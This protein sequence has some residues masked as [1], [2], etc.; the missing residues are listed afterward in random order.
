MWNK[1][2]NFIIIA[3]LLF[4]GWAIFID[5]TLYKGL[6]KSAN[7]NYTQAAS[8]FSQPALPLPYTGVNKVMF[9][10]GF[11]P[12]SIKTSSANGYNYFVKIV[13]AGTNQELGSYFIRSGETLDTKVPLGTYEM[14]CATG[15]QWYGTLH[16]FGPETRYSKADPPLEFYFDGHIY[17]G[18]AI[19]LIPQINGNLKTSVIIPS[20]W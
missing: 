1:I 2:Q 10:D 5:D 8:T 13:Y 6:P 9:S 19:Q 20:Q 16:L 4:I 3:G 12:L 15:K 18:N 17:Q 11:A 7:I 14:K